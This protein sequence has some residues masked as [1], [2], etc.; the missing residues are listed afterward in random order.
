MLAG[1][2]V[3]FAFGLGVI[4]YC[5]DWQSSPELNIGGIILLSV[6]FGILIF[7]TFYVFGLYEPVRFKRPEALLLS[8]CLAFGILFVCYSSLAYF[9]PVLR[10]GK[11]LLVF[12]T[13]LA[14]TLAFIWRLGFA[15]MMQLEP[16]RVLFI[17]NNKLIR[18]LEEILHAQY[19]NFYRITGHWHRTS[20][21]PTLPDFETYIQQQKIDT[22]VYSVHS[23]I[24]QDV[25]PSL[26]NTRFKQK[27]IYDS[28]MFYQLVTGKFPIHYMDDFWMLMN[29]RREIFFPGIKNKIK[30]F[31]DIIFAICVLPVALP[32]I[33]IA[34]L[35][36]KLETKGP[37]LFIQ[38]RLGLNE[39]PFLC[40]KLR[41]MIHNAEKLTG[42]KWAEKNDQRITRVG[43]VLRK[44][45]LDELPQ[46]FNVLR[47]DMS[48]VGPRPMRKF[49]TDKLAEEFPYYRMR[50][51]V[52]PGLT[53][54]AQVN[55][56]LA[57][58]MDI[59]S[60][61]IQYDLYYL[62]HPSFFLDLYI[63]LKTIRVMVWGKGT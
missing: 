56:N 38:E 44:L 59:E 33:L 45:S 42:P 22:I 63:I 31:F 15:R 28:H 62:M 61:K 16:Q 41:T 34:G 3:I 43:W 37:A 53:G 49:F 39:K 12:F 58:S 25:T 60:E 48:V 47:G 29:S 57:R 1:D 26:I 11:I 23:E 21:N 17:G 20:H 6:P 19:Q 14:A 18:E 9:F 13:V 7:I 4:V 36:I 32:L 8:I 24:L 51:L 46:I 2:F 40:Y 30:R 10:P 35:A 50:F 54:W 52:K 27:N 55:Q 5:K